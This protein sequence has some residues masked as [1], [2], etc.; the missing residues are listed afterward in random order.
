MTKTNKLIEEYLRTK[1]IKIRNKIVEEN[2]GLVR[3]TAHHYSQL[4][5]VE[6]EDL[7]QMGCIGLVKALDR[8]NPEFDVKLSTFVIPSIRGEITH[9]LRDK[10]TTLK[11]PRK[12]ID[13][14]K[15]YQ[16]LGKDSL[17][18][19]EFQMVKD[20]ARNKR[21]TSLNIKTGVNQNDT[22]MN[23]IPDEN[24][25][26]H[27]LFIE[28][29]LEFVDIRTRKM[30]VMVY[31]LDYTQQKTAELLGVKPVTVRRNLTKGLILI[32][33]KL[34]SQSEVSY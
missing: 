7:F 32:R 26:S 4:T 25:C 30:L 21:L 18:S 31:L 8:F 22:L 19:D 27:N 29:C 13:L 17:T 24:T 23:L 10:S 14:E 11:I 20:M 28:Q 5:N 6:Y 15:K 33:S 12:L 2:L 34:R 9:Y 3:K 1:D 16:K